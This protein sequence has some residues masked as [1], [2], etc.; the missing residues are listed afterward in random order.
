MLGW[1]IS[2]YTMVPRNTSDAPTKDDQPST[3][4]LTLTQMDSL[5]DRFVQGNQIAA[6]QSG[7]E[8]LRWIDEIVE[9]GAAIAVSTDGY[10]SLF[11]AKALDVL[12]RLDSPPEARGI[13][14]LDPN[15]ILTEHWAG[16]TVINESVM[17]ACTPDQWLWIEA[18]DES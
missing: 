17:A 11:C 13:R 12:P 9:S 2:V 4:G 1:D 5:R 16:R 10:P 3:R 8:G 18:W 15:G 7:V 14:H 6:W